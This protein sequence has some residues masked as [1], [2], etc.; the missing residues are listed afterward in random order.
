MKKIS[1]ISLIV[2]IIA[3]ISMA[4]VFTN[5]SRSEP[6]KTTVF[7]RVTGCPNCENLKYC[8]DGGPLIFAGQCDFSFNC[9]DGEHYICVMCS[10]EDTSLSGG[11]SVVCSGGSVKVKIE[12][13]NSTQCSC[14]SSKKK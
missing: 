5:D 13:T 9:S 14:G 10:P 3:V 1:V 11:Q 12:V 8:I 2:L 7:V 4:F 6:A